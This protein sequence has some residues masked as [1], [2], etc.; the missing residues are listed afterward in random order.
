MKEPRVAIIISSY[1]QEK[2][3]QENIKNLE[4]TNYKNYKIYLV[5]DSGN[6]KIAKKVAKNFPKVKII[7]NV[8]NSGFSKSYN[9]GIKLAKK[10]CDPIWFLI[11]NDD[12]ELRDRNWLKNILNFS[13]NKTSGGIFGCKITYPDGSIQR[14]VKKNKTYFY[15]QSG[16][17]EQENE[18]SEN[19][20]VK[21]IMG[22]FMFIKKEVFEKVGYFDEGFSPF[23]G[24]ESDLCFRAKKAGFEIWY[25]GSI[26][27]IHHRNKSISKF[28]KED[29]WF[30]RKKNSIRLEWKHYSLLKIIYYGLIHFGSIFKG[31][32]LEK[33]KKFNLLFKAYG[34]N[35]GKLKKI[36]TFRRS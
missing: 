17:K 11:L 30:I 8:K 26:N 2:L 33:E 7:A 5:D 20:E 19:C 18:F 9:A 13:Q 12:C 3:I 10:D 27:L 34:V 24:E 6:K 4:K 1:N 35:F 16:I 25:N 29:V 22:A 28:T 21:E 14:G 23:Y 36:K 31:D 15:E 32:G